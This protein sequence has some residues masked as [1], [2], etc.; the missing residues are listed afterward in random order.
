MFFLFL[1]SYF[2]SVLLSSDIIFWLIRLVWSQVVLR[3][4]SCVGHGIVVPLVVSV[5][6]TLQLLGSNVFIGVLSEWINPSVLD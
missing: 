6:N 3:A 2:Y 5:S 1:M 4:G